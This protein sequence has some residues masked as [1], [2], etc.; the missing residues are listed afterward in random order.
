M[1]TLGEAKA[2]ARIV[3]GSEGGCR[4]CINEALQELNTAFPKFN[5]K[6][7]PVTEHDAAIEV[8]RIADAPLRQSY[9]PFRC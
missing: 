7:I 6:L 5:W 4:G 1:M 2:V 8:V 9:R 3:E